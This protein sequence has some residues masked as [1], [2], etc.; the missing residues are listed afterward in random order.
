LDFA[1]RVAGFENL[2]AKPLVQLREIEAPPLAI[3]TQRVSREYTFAGFAKN[4][5]GMHPKQASSFS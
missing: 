2:R 1:T 5:F 4:G 3:D